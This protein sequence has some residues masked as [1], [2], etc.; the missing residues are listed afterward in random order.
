MS[1]LIFLFNGKERIIDLTDEQ[2]QCFKRN[3]DQGDIRIEDTYFAP[4]KRV[5]DKQRYLLAYQAKV[6]GLLPPQGGDPT[7]FTTGHDNEPVGNCGGIVV[8][9]ESPHHDEY[10]DQFNPIGPAQGKTGKYFHR[11]F[12]S[13]VLPIL[14]QQGLKLDLEKQY[15]VTL[16][17]PVPY[18]A[19]LACLLTRSEQSIKKKVWNELWKSGCNADFNKRLKS[20]APTIVLNGC[21]TDFKQVVW[22]SVTETSPH[23][24]HFNI[25]H[26]A[27]WQSC[28]EPFRSQ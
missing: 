6:W 4:E 15:P 1:K 17:N 3:I 7:D 18:Q 23:A 9:L 26:P 5:P 27:G 12:T 11:Y 28:F 14:L 22:A 24:Q 25:S 13:H 16:V 2:Q 21:T 19:S 10:D 20:Y 8:L